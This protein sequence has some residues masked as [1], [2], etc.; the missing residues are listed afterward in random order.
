[1]VSKSAAYVSYSR[2]FQP[3]GEVLAFTTTQA[4]MGPE[5]TSNLEAG[6][7]L[8]LFGG[9]TSATAA[10]FELERSDI[11]TTVPGTTTIVP[12]GEQRTRGFELAV[13]GEIARG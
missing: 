5:Q 13:A 2:S 4:E 3:S 8:D 9:K 12:V 1:M 11:K 6:V 10:V 7:K